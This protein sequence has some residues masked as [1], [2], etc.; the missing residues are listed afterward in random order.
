M[1]LPENKEKKLLPWRHAETLSSCCLLWIPVKLDVIPNGQREWLL[2][3]FSKLSCYLKEENQLHGE[4]F[5]QMQIIDENPAIRQLF[6][7]EMLKE[8]PIAGVSRTPHQKEVADTPSSEDIDAFAKKRREYRSYDYMPTTAY[9]FLDRDEAE[10]RQR[11][12]GYG[13]L[14]ILYRKQEQESLTDKPAATA[15]MPPLMIPRFLRQDPRVM[16]LLDGFDHNNPTQMPTFLRN[17]SAMKQVLSVFDVNKT[18]RKGDLLLSPFRDQSKE[19]FGEHMQRDLK[20]EALPFILPRFSSQDFFA[21][22]EAQIRRWFEVFDIYVAESPHD[23]GIIMACKD[24][25][26]ALIATIVD[27]MRGK[28]YR[29]WEG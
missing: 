5:M 1:T 28:G 26:T 6:L 2:S 8:T 14:T 21:H 13:G 3:F 25:L 20:F 19:I 24:N 16:E 17:H 11:Y 15:T 10:L 12:L 22:T 23:E 7:N 9:W 29:Y 4:H 18:Q 27:E